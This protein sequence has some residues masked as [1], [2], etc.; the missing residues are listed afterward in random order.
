MEGL[1]KGKIEGKIEGEL[2]GE[3]ESL[4]LVLN[5]SLVSSIRSCKGESSRFPQ[6]NKLIVRCCVRYKSL[7]LMS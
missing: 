3:I 4:F 2:K 6:V 7:P 5:S 1:N